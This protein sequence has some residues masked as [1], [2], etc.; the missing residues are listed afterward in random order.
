M[1]E[2]RMPQLGADMA[3][4]TLT[5]WLRK[6]GDAVIRDEG[7]GAAGFL[8]EAELRIAIIGNT[9]AFRTPA[10]G[11]DVRA[12]FATDGQVEFKVDGASGDPIRQRWSFKRGNRLCRALRDGR[13]HCIRAQKDRETGALTFVH[14]K[15]SYQVTVIKGKQLSQ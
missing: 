4:G 2:F 12:Y 11:R 15:F 1:A 8:S 10:N 5:E 6:P 3:A 13:N 9:L 14:P 7:G